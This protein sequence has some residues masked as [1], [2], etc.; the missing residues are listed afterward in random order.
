[1]PDHRVER[2]VPTGHHHL[3]FELDG[4]E[5][6]VYDNDTLEPIRSYRQVWFAGIHR[7]HITISPQEMSE[8]FVVRFRAAPFE[9]V[10]SP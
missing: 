6:H 1:M 8:M 5:R 10:S 2:V 3:I 7:E 4:M 9:N